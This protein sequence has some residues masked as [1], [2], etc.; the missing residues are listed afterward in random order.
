M[1]M[2]DMETNK[3][4]RPITNELFLRAENS[5]F[6]LIFFYKVVWKW[7]NHKTKCKI[8]FYHKNSQLKELKE[9]QK[10]VSNYSYDTEFK[11]FIK[12]F[13]YHTTEPHSFFMERYNFAIRQSINIQEKSILKI[14]DN[15]KI[16]T[17]DNKKKQLK[18]LFPHQEALIN[19]NF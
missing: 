1:L 7:L 16:K 9:L 4:S 17:I 6:C 14:N 3:D 8:S 15:N 19:M 10:V 18:S 13:K 11:D 12:L 2:V 5:T